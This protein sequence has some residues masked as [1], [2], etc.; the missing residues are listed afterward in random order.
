MRLARRASS[1][2]TSTRKGAFGDSLHDG[3][4]NE[5]MSARPLSVSVAAIVLG[6][7][8]LT[9]LGTWLI[10]T[11][12]MSAFVIYSNFMLGVAGLAAT[13]GLWLLKRWGMWL[14]LLVSA[15]NILFAAPALLFAPTSTQRVLAT[16]SIVGFGLVILLVVLPNSRR[17]YT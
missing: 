12:G 17:A 2:Q 9:N 14:A 6:L 15:L 3:R 5:R 11:G 10:A 8:S 1:V 13:G 4:K 7:G 16:I